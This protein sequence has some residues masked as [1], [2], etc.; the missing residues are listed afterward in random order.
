MSRRILGPWQMYPNVTGVTYLTMVL[1]GM[2]RRWLKPGFAVL[3]ELVAYWLLE[4]L[5]K[6]NFTQLVIS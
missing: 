3:I 5:S 1:E 6:L 4:V 2:T